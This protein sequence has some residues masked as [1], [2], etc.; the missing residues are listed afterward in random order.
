[1]ISLDEY[2][3]AG[4]VIIPVLANTKKASVSWRA[5]IDNK[6]AVD[7]IKALLA[8]HTGNYAV[9]T[10]PVSGVIVVD[11]DAPDA[12]EGFIKT[13][14]TGRV[15]KTPSGGYHLYYAY[16]GNDIG[17]SVSKIG[18][19]LDVRGRGGYVLIPPSTIDGTAYTWLLSGEPS[20]L[21]AGL[22]DTI[23]N[24][25][26]AVLTS[27]PAPAPS[28][29][30]ENDQLDKNRFTW[31]K[32]LQNGFTP[33]AHNNEV[34]YCA[35]YLA[36]SGM[37]PEE[38]Y[39]TLAA[40]NASDPTP[41]TDAELRA[42]IAS[43]LG[44]VR[45]EAPQGGVSSEPAADVFDAVPMTDFM[46]RYDQQDIFDTWLIED[47]LP[48]QSIIMV[49]A[50]PEHYK[51]WLVLDA[52]LTVA[53]G[54]EFTPFLTNFAA[55]GSPEPVYIFQ[56]EDHP[57]QVAHRLNMIIRRKIPPGAVRYVQESDRHILEF[58]PPLLN[59]PVY[60]HTSGVLTL[61]DEALDKL[62]EKIK[63]LGIKLCVIDPFYMLANAEDYFA[64]AARQ[65]GRLKAIRNAY[66]TAFL[67]A[68]HNRK[69][70]GTGRE[71]VYGSQLLNGAVEGMW[72]INPKSSEGAG[73]LRPSGY[74]VTVTGKAFKS[75]ERYQ[76]DIKVDRRIDDETGD[77][78]STYAFE[79]VNVSDG[80]LTAVLSTLS[81]GAL[82]FDDLYDAVSASITITRSTFRRRLEAM[83]GRQ[84]VKSE[85]PN[86]DGRRGR[87]RVVYAIRPDMAGH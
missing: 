11:I 23:L 8:G 55:G 26:T 28:T 45:K 39:K 38:I 74:D 3:E 49:S 61:Q 18:N 2:V 75:R 62:E 15:A 56:Q 73:A 47:W 44:H 48:A 1:M 24:G 83:V 64:S 53:L 51:M 30:P 86:S 37:L 31:L 25:G 57:G 87:P 27:A 34:L 43:A 13:Y 20:P 63:G 76:L 40:L 4:W 12:Y 16:R 54:K 79:A 35:A 81:R 84:I 46:V 77:E 50:P 59:V 70:G 32:V 17:N 80:T 7:E 10:G 58:K 42:T 65:M 5:Y 72:L 36:R 6:P 41:Q 22:R 29:Q 14:P 71:A 82:A 9:L 19:L 67:I 85:Q 78:V 69:S 21:P 52:A 66:G 68:H 33:N 60:F